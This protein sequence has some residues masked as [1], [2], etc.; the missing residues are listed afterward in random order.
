MHNGQL[1]F[2]AQSCHSNDDDQN[3]P[4][5]RLSNMNAKFHKKQFTLNFVEMVG[6][7]LH[8]PY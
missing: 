2:L 4:Q 7:K 6:D 5:H 1:I 8:I 3:M